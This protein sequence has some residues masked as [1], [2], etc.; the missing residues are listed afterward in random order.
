MPGLQ[1]ANG[2]VEENEISVAE[3]R[4][5]LPVIWDALNRAEPSFKLPEGSLAA[6]QD[7]SGQLG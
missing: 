3:F 2:H 6:N 4:A 5:L 7:F 1:F